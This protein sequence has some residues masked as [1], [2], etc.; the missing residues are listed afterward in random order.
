[1]DYVQRLQIAKMQLELDSN[2]AQM[3][4]V[5]AQAMLQLFFLM[6]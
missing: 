2:A 5:V 1:M 6:A 4:V 3:N